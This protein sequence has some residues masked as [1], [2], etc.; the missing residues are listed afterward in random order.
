VIAKQAD[1]RRLLIQV[2][3]R[4]LLNTV[5]DDRARDRER[6]DLIRLARLALCL[7]G[8]SHAVRRHPHDPLAGG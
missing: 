1:L 3:D 4:E 5:L 2:R 8:R 7:A 6:I